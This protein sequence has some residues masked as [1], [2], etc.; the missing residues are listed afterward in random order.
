MSTSSSPTEARRSTFFLRAGLL[1][2]AVVGLLAAG[3]FG[4]RHL[5][6]DLASR[7][8]VPVGP[9][10]EDVPPQIGNIH[11]VRLSIPAHYLFFPVEYDGESV[12]A[13]RHD[14]PVRT[15]DSQISNFAVYVQWPAFRPRLPENEKSYHASLREPGAHDWFRVALVARPDAPDLVASP[16]LDNGLARILK[17]YLNH[18]ERY[19]IPKDVRY[20]IRG[21][22]PRLQLSVA[23][24]VGPRTEKFHSWNKVFYWTGDKDRHVST[25][26]KCWNGS[27]SNPRT[28]AECRHSFEL[29]EIK[30][31]I[32]ITYKAN[33]LPQ[34]REIEAN[35]RSLIL[36]FQVPPQ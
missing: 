20:E 9:Y 32:T 33:W 14:K 7:Y 30:S 22:D 26:I 25:L 19:R 2:F 16:Q 10:T 8:K 6:A 29:P 15:F 28:V 18:P 4:W 31:D 17:G 24:P 12:W 5:S 3:S 11:G 1:A 13:P 36:S 35:A 23:L 21:I 34:W 27:F